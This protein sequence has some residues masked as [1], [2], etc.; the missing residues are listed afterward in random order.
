[1]VGVAIEAVG[2]QGATAAGTARALNV[3][4]NTVRGWRKCFAE[5][6]GLLFSGFARATVALG[7]ALPTSAGEPVAGAI[8]LL[9]AP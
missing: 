8:A 6:A 3:P 2:T 9:R 4:R 7:R 5:R 1:M